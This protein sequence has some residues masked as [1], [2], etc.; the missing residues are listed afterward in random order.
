MNVMV[1]F[2]SGARLRLR[3]LAL[4]GTCEVGFGYSMAKRTHDQGATG[5]NEVLMI[6]R[7]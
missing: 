2:G 5:K 7:I 3:D 6:A 1:K 4:K